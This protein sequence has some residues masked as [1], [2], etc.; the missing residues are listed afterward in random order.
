MHQIGVGVLGPVFRTYE[1]DGDRLVALKAF[2]LDLTPERSRTLA[3]ALQRI[4]RVSDSHP[5]LVTP[6]SGGLSD[7]IPYLAAEYVAAESLDVAIRHHAPAAVE[8]ALPLIV[9][10]ADG[11]DTAHAWGLTHGALH[12]RDVF[13]TPELARITGLGVVPA[14]EQV[15]LRG[16]LRRPYT[17][18]EQLS[19]DE[20]GPAADRFALAA[21]VYEL[22]TGHR[23]AGTPEQLTER[24][25]A[26]LGTRRATRLA[27]LFAAALAIE[28]TARPGS[29]RLFADQL[30]DAVGWTGAEAVR[31]AMTHSDGP[32]TVD[33]TDAENPAQSSVAGDD[34]ADGTAHDD[35]R[36]HDGRPVVAGAGAQTEGAADM[37]NRDRPDETRTSELDWSE[38]SL[39]RGEAEELR[40]TEE[41][42]PRPVG[43]PPGF[44]R[45]PEPKRDA[46][47]VE[48]M[49]GI[50]TDDG[51]DYTL[52]QTLGEVQDA[53][54]ARAADET[55]DHALDQSLDEAV[56]AQASV[57]GSRP[58]DRPSAIESWDLDLSAALDPD[59]DGGRDVDAQTVSLFN[60]LE[61][62]EPEPSAGHEA[63]AR[64]P[65]GRVSMP[66]RAADAK[67]DSG[68]YDGMDDEY[69]VA[70]PSRARAEGERLAA[71]PPDALTAAVYEPTRLSDLADRLGDKPDDGDEYDDEGDRDDEA[72]AVPDRLSDQ[73]DQGSDNLQARDG[74]HPAPIRSRRAPAT[75]NDLTDYDYD[76]D[77][78]ANQE[79]EPRDDVAAPVVAGWESSTRRLP[80]VAL[81][82]LVV[83]VSA[84][85]FAIG[86]GWLS[87][88]AGENMAADASLTTG[89]EG[90]RTN[91]ASVNPDDAA[92]R[93]Y[94][95]STEP[96]LETSST[97]P[98]PISPPVEP[99]T[100]TS[101]AAVDASNPAPTPA[102]PPTP[103]PTLAP[104]A[105]SDGR[106]LVRSTPPG[107]QVTVNGEPRG[108]TPLALSD[109]QYAAYDVR[110]T[111]EGY[112]TE[113]RRLTISAAD[114]I[115]A[116][117]AP[118][119]PVVVAR[120]APL[121]VGSIFVDTRPPGVQV[122]LDQQLVGDTPM[123]IPDV[124][125]GSHDVEFKRDGYRK[126]AT[127]VQV[128]SETQSRVTAS[129]APAP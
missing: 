49:D 35:D 1:P 26:V 84:G 39:D 4:A 119:T 19:S 112:E 120:N 2:H 16:P 50:D 22:L 21:I 17:A 87:S 9:Q 123:L 127:T 116:V 14:L 69:Q 42:Q 46:P 61:A 67:D 40:Q 43:P 29:A 111:F 10:L 48:D 109:L 89:I 128:G 90:P 70:E 52:D 53:A 65:L 57:D 37:A 80:V 71:E 34:V 125:A 56:G 122:W 113:D 104:A 126:W 38:R 62:P 18:P 66:P 44:E 77:G 33:R 95:E 59:A 102:P 45:P 101:V 105:T 55:T 78:D 76:Y 88:G 5:A 72:Y 96:T 97:S 31:D 51:L 94:S 8:N 60:D 41:Y 47:R 107:A 36:G 27:P 110:L 25:V 82:L 7:D 24:L 54:A 98:A 75:P 23:A 86:F 108:T 58:D 73:S 68:S 103:N 15:G 92:G 12:L 121:G 83:A 106:L 99:E 124:A 20:W 91:V 117:Q 11:L 85:A 114:P 32:K 93:E 6:L 64:Q 79:D 81:V 13:V 118:L 74:D 30:A 100:P 63:A 129:L 3:E 28:P 115:A